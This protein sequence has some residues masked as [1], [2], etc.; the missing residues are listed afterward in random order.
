MSDSRRTFLRATTGLI[1][2]TALHSRTA[3]AQSG[4]RAF[5]KID[6]KLMIG[7]A[8]HCGNVAPYP[9]CDHRIHSL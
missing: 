4:G 2:G 3:R 1:V 7:L 6:P 9:D 5:P 8:A